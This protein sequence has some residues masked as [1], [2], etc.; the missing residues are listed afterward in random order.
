MRIVNLVIFIG[1]VVAGV[2][3]IAGTRLDI[4]ETISAPL[5]MFATVTG[6][7]FGL[8]AALVFLG[9]ALARL[10]GRVLEFWRSAVPANFGLTILGV[11]FLGFSASTVALWGIGLLIGLLLAAGLHAV[12]AINWPPLPLLVVALLAVNHF[13]AL[14]VS[15]TVLQVAIGAVLIALP[16]FSAL[17]RPRT[18]STA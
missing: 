13:V 9:A 4:G 12:R 6:W 7:L 15:P 18:A 8:V 5:L 11:S 16:V 14:G 2:A 1:L 10:S 17:G 3:L